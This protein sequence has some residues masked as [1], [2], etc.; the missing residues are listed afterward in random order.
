MIV[1]RWSDG[2]WTGCWYE[3]LKRVTLSQLQHEW[4]AIEAGAW[5]NSAPWNDRH[6]QSVAP[7]RSASSLQDLRCMRSSLTC[8][9]A[10][11]RIRLR[12]RRMPF[13]LLMPT[14]CF[15]PRLYLCD[16]A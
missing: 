10:Y 8:F 9:Q 7:N 12:R 5:G 4:P 15:T 14:P 13:S 6:R 11:D 1:E 2:K 16:H 3:R